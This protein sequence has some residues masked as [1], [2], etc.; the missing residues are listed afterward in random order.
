[1][2][3]N[4]GYERTDMMMVT[5]RNTWRFGERGLRDNADVLIT[6]VQVDGFKR[7]NQQ[8]YQRSVEFIFNAYLFDQPHSGLIVSRSTSSHRR[9]PRSPSKDDPNIFN[10]TPE[11]A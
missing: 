2:F 3:V 4:V 10:G 11:N 5:G 8:L 1:M 6:V 7:V 9:Q